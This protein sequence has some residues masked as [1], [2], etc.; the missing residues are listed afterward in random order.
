MK[1]AWK[2][3]LYRN[4]KNI[5]EA[6]MI[7]NSEQYMFFNRQTIELEEQLS[8]KLTLRNNY[9]QNLNKLQEFMKEVKRIYT[10][11]QNKFIEK[12][13]KERNV[14]TIREITTRLYQ[15]KENSLNITEVFKPIKW[16]KN[17]FLEFAD[18]FLMEYQ[19]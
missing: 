12:I 19:N 9:E 17:E 13:E 11:S 15:Y 4:E 2:K 16:V 5:Q 3:F 10:Y 1:Q 18:L 14:Y 7:V 8:H 6:K